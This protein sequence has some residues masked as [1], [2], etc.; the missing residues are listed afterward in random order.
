MG[1]NVCGPVKL[2]ESVLDIGNGSNTDGW[3]LFCLS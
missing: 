2:L 1:E 3:N